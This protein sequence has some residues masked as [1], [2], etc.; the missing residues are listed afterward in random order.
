MR[1]GGIRIGW[2]NDGVIRNCTF[3]NLTMTDTNVGIDLVLP[4]NL[5]GVR[6]S[7]EGEEATL[8]ENL[9]FSNITMDRVFYEP[10]S[11][12]IEENC[13]CDCIRNLYLT[14]I[15][16]SSAHMP[17]II[18]RQDC[19]VQNVYFTNC[20]FNQIRREEIPDQE[21]APHLERDYTLQP[22]FRHVNNLMLQD[23]AFSVL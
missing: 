10:V 2:I 20:H 18:G 12:R 15:H 5:T 17:V 19:P 13:R 7:D 16:A 21:K 1:K 9:N 22:Y 3:S 4:G 6:L 8:V 14:S 11:V 23:T